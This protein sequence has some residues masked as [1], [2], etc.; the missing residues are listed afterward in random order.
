MPHEEEV[1][2]ELWDL[3]NLRETRLLC[4][5]MY[6]QFRP[7]VGG[8]V[9]EVGAGIGTFSELLLADS[10]VTDLMLIEPDRA[11]AEILLD[12]FESDPRVTVVRETL[13]DSP[14]LR[15]RADKVDFLLCQNV[16]EHIER[17]GP[18]M[19][20]MADALRPDGRL[21]L[22]VPAHPS[23]Y[24]SL[25][26]VYGHHRRYTRERLRGVVDEAGLVLDDLYS[27]NLLGA[28]GWWLNGFRRLPRISLASLRV[29]AALLR[30]WQPIERI[31]RPPCGLSLIAHTHKP[32]SA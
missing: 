24:G 31:R 15:M 11:C 1:H 25:D 14:A 32:G 7:F 22:L 12:A 30:L 18:A 20:A 5:W 3:E 27:F 28:P 16:L 8:S 13:P 2:H 4:S 9:V 21:T 10:T 17:D 23:L 29:Y 6:E 26:R 19:R